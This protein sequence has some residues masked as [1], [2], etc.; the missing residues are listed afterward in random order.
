MTRADEVPDTDALRLAATHA[1]EACRLDTE[2]AEA[3]ST[4]GFI[5]ERVGKRTDAVAA[6]RRAIALRAR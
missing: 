6:G 3:W 2:N 1:Y 5:L 4:L